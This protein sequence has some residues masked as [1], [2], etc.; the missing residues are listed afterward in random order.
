MEYK[1]TEAPPQFDLNQKPVKVLD[2]V[3]NEMAGVVAET[4]ARMIQLSGQQGKKLEM[5]NLV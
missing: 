2:G 4:L 5:G 1:K 3:R